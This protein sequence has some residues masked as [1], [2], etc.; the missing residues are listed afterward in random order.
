M[1]ACAS[2]LAHEAR[3][4][5]EREPTCVGCTRTSGVRSQGDRYPKLERRATRISKKLRNLS[6]EK[7]VN[8]SDAPSSTRSQNGVSS[9]A[10]SNMEHENGRIEL[11][12]LGK[13]YPSSRGRG[14]SGGSRQMSPEKEEVR[15]QYLGD[16]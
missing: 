3:P 16:D 4:G 2:L 14:A 12:S 11:I 7:I 15:I 8:L 5:I 13:W 9:C 1:L 6:E 10:G